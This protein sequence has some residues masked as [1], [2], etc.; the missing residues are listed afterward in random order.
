[1]NLLK[2]PVIPIAAVLTLIAAAFH[3]Y[4]PI[5]ESTRFSLPWLGVCIGVTGFP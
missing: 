3:W 5:W 4:F 2:L 1:M